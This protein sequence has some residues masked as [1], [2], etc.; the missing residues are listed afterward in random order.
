VDLK[1]K[2]TE[3]LRRTLHADRVILEDDGGISGIVVSG[4]FQQLASL[5]RQQIIQKALQDSTLKF[6]KAELRQILAIAALTPLE[7]EALGYNGK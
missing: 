6:T 1:K 2:V 5:D 7:F 4:E 3:A